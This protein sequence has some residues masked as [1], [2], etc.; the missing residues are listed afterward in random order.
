MP[1]LVELVHA[2]VKPDVTLTTCSLHL[3]E[4]WTGARRLGLATARGGSTQHRA[5]AQAAPVSAHLAAAQSLGRG[6]REQG[7]SSGCL[8]APPA[9]R[10]ARTSIVRPCVR[11]TPRDARRE[12]ARP[13]G[14]ARGPS[15]WASRA[16]E[17]DDSALCDDAAR[18]GL[19]LHLLA[20]AIAGAPLPALPSRRLVVPRPQVGH[21][22][23]HR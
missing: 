19:G 20:V 15:P 2:V 8:P 21:V 16:A 4:S 5:T 18:R 14:R 12:G 22:H 1:G 6:R 13:R 17:R 11:R 3:S 9:P 23:L 10:V 7:S